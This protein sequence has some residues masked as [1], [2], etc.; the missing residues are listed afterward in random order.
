MKK[1]ILTGVTVLAMTPMFLSNASVAKVLDDDPMDC[2]VVGH[3]AAT[4]YCTSN[5][6]TQFD[7]NLVATF[8]YDLCLEQGR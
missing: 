8:H 4:S 1:I 3:Y 2:A 6:C 5:A 7:F